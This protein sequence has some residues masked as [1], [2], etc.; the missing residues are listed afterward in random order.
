MGSAF[1]LVKSTKLS[2]FIEGVK[3]AALFSSGKLAWVNMEKGVPSPN[4]E[5]LFD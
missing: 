5:S 1:L 4:Q 2:V 3:E